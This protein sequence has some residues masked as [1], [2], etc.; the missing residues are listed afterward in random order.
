MNQKIYISLTTIPSRIANLYNT[1]NSLLSQ[2]LMADKII[3]NIPHSYYRFPEI[4]IIPKF[5]QDNE[6]IVINRCQDYGPATKLLGLFTYPTINNDDILIICDDDR[7][8]DKNFIVD[9]IDSINIFPNCAVTNVGWDIEEMSSF[10][11]M[12]KDMP[13]GKNFSHCG[14][15]DILGGCCGFAIKYGY[16][17][18]DKDILQIKPN[19]PIFFVDDV[20]IS[21]HL[22]KNN[23][24]ILIVSTKNDA[25]RNQNNKIQPLAIMGGT[26]SRDNC[27]NEAIKYFIDKYNIW[28]NNYEN[29]DDDTS[30][31][32]KYSKIL[33]ELL[34]KLGIINI[35]DIG[36]HNF[37]ILKQNKFSHIN[38]LG[39]GTEP[40]Q[41]LK[42]DNVQ[43]QNMDTY[44]TNIQKTDLTILPSDMF[45]LLNSIR[46]NTKY[47]L[48][49][50]HNNQHLKTFNPIPVMD[51]KSGKLF[52]IIGELY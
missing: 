18:G 42:R 50:I 5:L 20:W 46:K 39:I 9:L 24:K 25:V 2:T 35:V 17:L 32:L 3:I 37:P 48:V 26:Y 19:I 34:L 1:I 40:R 49:N 23:I 27:N 44:I 14:Y 28:N 41:I 22:T 8:Y 7:N 11:Y 43:F 12:K 45:S 15:V 30:F 51:H 10:S 31:K 47:I 16:L 6:K 52:L 33:E 29:L 36:C 13:R 21:G 38:Y 4:P